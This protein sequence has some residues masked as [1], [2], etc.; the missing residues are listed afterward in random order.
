MKRAKMQASFVGGTTDDIEH[1]FYEALHN[2]D[3]EQLMSCWAEEDDIVCVHPGGPRIIGPGAVRS[4]FEAMFAKGSVQAYP[5][6]IH[7]IESLAC[8]V[9]HLV[10]RVEL[11]GQNGPQHAWV[12]A[13]N[14]YH[15]TPQG[16]R[17]VVHHTS[18]GTAHDAADQGIKPTIFH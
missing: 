3:I 16:W 11:I 2:A 18:P 10:E 5:E 7:K 15:K 1:A 12:I 17:M 4:V 13:T 9:H 8:A 6:R 14:V